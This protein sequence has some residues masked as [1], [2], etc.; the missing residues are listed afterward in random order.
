MEVAALKSVYELFPTT[1]KIVD[2]LPKAVLFE[3]LAWDVLNVRV[4][5]FTAKWH[6]KSQTGALEALDSTDEFRA[7][8]AGLQRVLKR[9]DRALLDLRDGTQLA[10]VANDEPSSSAS[11]SGDRAGLP[12]GIYSLTGGIGAGDAEQ[13]QRRGT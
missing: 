11:Y 1:R 9:F 5:P 10:P 6:R 7:E 4:R 8:L 2:D 12:W 3:A 13:D